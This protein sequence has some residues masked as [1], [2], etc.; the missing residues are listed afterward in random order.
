MKATDNR[1]PDAG[2][3]VGNG[4]VL[5]YGGAAIAMTAMVLA[6][7]MP[8]EWATGLIATMFAF[9]MA[10]D[11]VIQQRDMETPGGYQTDRERREEGQEATDA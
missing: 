3:T 6:G 8:W 9:V 5:A 2:R 4:V 10:D 11:Y 7:H 1:T